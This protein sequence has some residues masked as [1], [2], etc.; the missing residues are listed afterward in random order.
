MK[1]LEGVL[2]SL[3]FWPDASVVADAGG[4]VVASN[5]ALSLLTGY[6]SAVL[7]G[8]ELTQVL[9]LRCQS[10]EPLEG[11]LASPALALASVR[12]ISEQRLRMRRAD[13]ANVE[14]FATAALIR[15]D[16]GAVVAAAVSFRRPR[17]APAQSGMR[18]V[19]A[20][21]HELRS[22]LT[23][24]KGYTSLML[25]AWDRLQDDQKRDMVTQMRRDG[26]RVARVINELIHVARLETATLALNRQMVWLPNLVEVVLATARE[27]FAS[28]EAT[29]S[30]APDLFP[31]VLIDEAKI[32][33]ALRN[34][35]ENA[36]KY[37]SEKGIEIRLEVVEQ[38]LGSMALMSVS[39][40]GPGLGPGEE[41]R[42]F[43]KLYRSSV[44]RPSGSGLG[45]WI[46]RGIAEAHGGA[47]RV[48]RRARG[49]TTFTMS[50][51]IDPMEPD[52]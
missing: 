34:L 1:D 13:G 15:S 30:Y 39:D 33:E 3:E 51:P 46:A 12:R 18:V 48:H 31:S 27:E 37:G 25:K 38:G 45:L 29:T 26:D 41:D 21:G 7:A 47:L 23:S 2:G 52:A 10:G 14:V 22:P 43:D 42:I 35:V 11:W 8:Q 20:I 40:R 24:I 50:L 19:S 9:G 4:V 44:S 16:S 17:A 32:S 49:G 36:C 6:P 28:L 5:R